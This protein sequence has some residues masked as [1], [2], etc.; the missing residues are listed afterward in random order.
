MKQISIL[1]GKTSSGKD[2][3]LKELLKND[4]IS[5]ISFTDRPKRKCETEGVEYYFE[6]KK[7]FQNLIDNDRLIEYREYHTCVDGKD[8]IWRYGLPKKELDKDKNYVVISDIEGAK[9]IIN[10]Y[11]EENCKVYYIFA[12]LEIRKRRCIERG[13]Y[14]EKEFNRRKDADDRDFSVELQ[15]SVK[16]NVIVNW[17]VSIEEIVKEIL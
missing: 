5:L 10:Y 14:N 4:C 12:P 17:K 8:D 11:G 9:S 1:C 13:D 15:H 2:T 6:S 3:I 16:A 7:G